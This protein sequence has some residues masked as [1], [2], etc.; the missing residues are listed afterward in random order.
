MT[1]CPICNGMDEI[2]VK[3]GK[4]GN[5]MQDN[6][7]VMDY[8]DGYSAYM[9]IDLM[10]LED[11]FKDTYSGNKCPHLMHCHSCQEEYVLL[12]KE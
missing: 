6:G 1:V 5:E 12:I 4:C 11:G 8:Y 10:K 9:S 2:H 3:C 7:R